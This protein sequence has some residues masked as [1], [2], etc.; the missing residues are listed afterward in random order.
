MS[1]TQPQSQSRQGDCEGSSRHT[2][3]SCLDLCQ[4]KATCLSSA[5]RTRPWVV[6]PP[7]R[8]G[9]LECGNGNLPHQ[10]L[11]ATYSAA[12]RTGQPP[13][14]PK[15]WLVSGTGTIRGLLCQQSLEGTK[16][17]EPLTHQTHG[18]RSLNGLKRKPKVTKTA[19]L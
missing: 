17:K 5:G 19:Y 14:F 6:P 18:L 3:G 11:T 13:E 9:C 1:R 15:S 16:I 8:C 4:A 2:R 7:A 12:T 10:L